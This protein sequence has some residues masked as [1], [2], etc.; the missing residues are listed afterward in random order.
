[1][2][3][4]PAVVSV[5][6]EGWLLRLGIELQHLSTNPN[7]SAAQSIKNSQVAKVGFGS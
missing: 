5:T 1:M 4:S 3:V 6:Q 7:V 2:L